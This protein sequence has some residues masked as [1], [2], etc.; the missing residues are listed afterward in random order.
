MFVS[1]IESYYGN[2]SKS[3]SFAENKTTLSYRI[4]VYYRLLNNNK[5]Y[6]E[7]YLISVTDK[8]RK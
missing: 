1:R 8:R 5:L 4:F 2:K 7:I 6:F 3:K